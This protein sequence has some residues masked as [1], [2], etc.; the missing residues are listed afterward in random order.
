[1]PPSDDPKKDREVF[2]KLMTMDDEGLLRRRSKNLSYTDLWD[3]LTEEERAAYFDLQKIEEGSAIHHCIRGD[4]REEKAELKEEMQALAFGRL[5]YEEKL[6]YCDRPEQIDGPSP[7]AWAEINAHLGTSAESLPELVR[8]LGERRFGRV[9]RV[10]DA[11]CGGGSI[12]FEAA[13]L[14]FEAYGSDLN[15]VAALLTWGALNIVGGGEE[16]AERVREAQERV[17]R[18]VDEQITEWGIEHNEQGW[19][20]D[21][22]LYCVEVRDPETG[23][24][25]PL[26][27][28]WVIG[29]RTNTIAK[30]EPNAA[31]RR[32]RHP[33][34]AGRLEEG[35]RS[36]EGGRH[37]PRQQ[38]LQPR[39]P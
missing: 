17:Y 12:P 6:N 23:M 34:Q 7:E 14:G 35:D 3:L 19:R 26:A 39:P 10:G 38:A 22:Y 32:V 24:M 11:F 9:P 33:H 29:E 1:M 2:L 4:S 18:A 8:E 15:P 31:R 36:G 37:R 20:A 21:A 16:V 5:T 28:S 13:R 25:V 30:L 27:P